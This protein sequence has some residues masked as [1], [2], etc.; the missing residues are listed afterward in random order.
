MKC[1]LLQQ[2]V[3][4][5]GSLRKALLFLFIFIMAFLFLAIHHLVREKIVF[6]NALLEE[7]VF[8]DPIVIY[9]LPPLQHMAYI[10]PSAKKVSRVVSRQCV[11]QHHATPRCAV[12]GRNRF[13][14]ILECGSRE[15][16]GQ[17]GADQFVAKEMKTS[18]C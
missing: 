14:L 12:N 11:E 15:V 8:Q 18:R 7:A 2:N 5:F 3:A 17:F 10:R 6:Q 9:R 16:L 13:D 1:I 4:A